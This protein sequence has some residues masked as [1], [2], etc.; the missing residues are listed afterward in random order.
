[1]TVPVNRHHCERPE[2]PQREHIERKAR[3]SIRVD[4][5]SGDERGILRSPEEK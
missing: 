3:T 1:M 4:G 5:V 2:K